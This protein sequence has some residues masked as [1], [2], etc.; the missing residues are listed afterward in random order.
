MGKTV[1]SSHWNKRYF[2]AKWIQTRGRRKNQKKDSPPVWGKRANLPRTTQKGPLNLQELMHKTKKV[3]LK[4]PEDQMCF[5]KKPK[6]GV[7]L[8]QKEEQSLL[9]V[10]ESVTNWNFVLCC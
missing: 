6:S 8:N 9:G 10:P 4:Q 5:P 3:D 2:Y 7:F 1:K